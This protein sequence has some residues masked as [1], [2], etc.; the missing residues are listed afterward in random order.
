MAT[1]IGMVKQIR[2]RPAKGQGYLKRLR[3]LFEGQVSFRS[4]Q[5]TMR[6]NWS[7]TT[8]R[9]SGHHAHQNDPELFSMDGRGRVFDII[10]VARLWRMVK[11]EYIYIKEYA[12]VQA[13]VAGLHDYF[14][15][16][17]CERPHQDLGY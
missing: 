3:D 1:A 4:Q 16:Y 14:Q 7:Y 10:F 8:A 9:Y 15:L 6:E 17:N 13:L 11:Y 5:T 2:P 12:S